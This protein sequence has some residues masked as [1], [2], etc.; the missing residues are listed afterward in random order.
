[1][2]HLYF[3]QVNPKGALVGKESS[4]EATMEIYVT[5]CLW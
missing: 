3:L 4:K 2:K 5:I 1:M